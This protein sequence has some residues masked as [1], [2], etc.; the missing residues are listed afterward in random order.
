MS[1]TRKTTAVCAAAM[2]L[3]LMGT[4]PPARA[5]GAADAGAATTPT[6]APTPLSPETLIR[7]ADLR[8]DA[9]VLRRAWETMHPGL[10]R[11]NTEADIE[12]AFSGLDAFFQ[13]DRTLK[14]AFLAFSEIAAKVRCGHTY[15]SPF[16]QRRAVAA[17]LFRGPYVPFHFRWLDRRMVITK[18]FA[19]EPGLSPGVEVLAINGVPVS[20]ILSRLLTLTRADGHN[21]SKRIALLEVMGTSRYE[22]FD[23]YWPLLF[24]S[25]KDQ[26]TLSIRG[27]G[28]RTP[29]TVSVAPSPT[30]QRE[31][32][33]A[34]AKP[35]ASNPVG[36]NFRMLDEGIGFLEMPDWALYNTK[37]DWKAYLNDVFREL[38]SSK[39]TALVIDL[40]ANE[41]G[42]DVGDEIVAHLT[43]RPAKRQAVERRVRYRKTP[44]DLNPFLDTW[45]DSFRDWGRAALAL[46]ARFFRLR[47]DADDD[48][49][50][51]IAPQA[52]RFA[53]RVYALIGATNS[54]ATFEFA[55]TLRQNGLG[56]LVGQ[57][58][59]GNQ[60][61]INGGAFFFLRLPKSGLEIDLPLIGQFPEGTRPDAGLEPDVRVVATLDD[62]AK[63]RDAEVEAVKRLIG[64]KP[65]AKP[66]PRR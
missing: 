37:W 38:I 40:R 49:A 64:R 4:A 39:A 36:W 1:V 11:Y 56:T 24:P 23:V 9:R 42:S 13:K 20:E 29:R 30:A 27:V 51:P 46:D 21:D 26:I 54:S 2:A 66:T 62:I 59:G 45:D 35:E 19:S 47:R 43:T 60:R 15:V 53:G 61:G 14:E 6:P 41:G 48:P 12:A 44:E 32:K 5:Q 34:P 65:D 7:A 22:T 33:A 17:A 55:Q 16:N 10:L 50:A 18:S 25:Q 31:D 52:P 3:S 8:E 28:E 58:T 63:G 57:T